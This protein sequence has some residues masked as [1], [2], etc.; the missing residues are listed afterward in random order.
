MTVLEPPSTFT[1]VHNGNKI[2]Y[3]RTGSGQPILFL[4]N[5]GSTKEIW[6]EQVRELSARYEVIC[7]DHLGFGESDMP[8]TGYTIGNYVAALSA[9]IDHLAVQ[10]IAVVGNC[11]GSAMTLLLAQHRPEIFSALVLINPLTANTARR[12]VIGWA[13]PFPARWPRLSMFVSRRLRVPKFLSRYVI[14][15]Q[16]GPRGWRRGLLKPLP[17][18]I[19]AGATWTTRG[20]LASMAEMFTDLTDFEA[21]DQMRPDADFPPLAVVWGNANLGLSPRAGRLLNQTLR[22]DRAEFL[23]RCGH[24]PMMEDPAAVTA[25]IDEFVADPPLRGSRS[26]PRSS[27][28]AS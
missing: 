24:L 11:M 25:I 28:R 27:G 5:G 26:L 15:G 1:F 12:G 20:R 14:A 9:F 22:P 2:A 3:T 8:E 4:H 23:P 17:G 16:Y 7:M 13:L 19:T 21:I 18:A 10:R 6:T